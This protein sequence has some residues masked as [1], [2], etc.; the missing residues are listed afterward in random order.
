MPYPRSDPRFWI[1]MECIIEYLLRSDY[2]D[3]FRLELERGRIHPDAHMR[4]A[5][6]LLEACIQRGSIK[7]MSVLLEYG[8]N[9]NPTTSNNPVLCLLE[10]MARPYFSVPLD[11]H[12]RMAQL[13]KAAGSRLPEGARFLCN[14]RK[15][16]TKASQGKVALLFVTNPLS[17]R[18]LAVHKIR[19]QLRQVGE[20][21]SRFAQA[22]REFFKSPALR[23]SLPV[24]VITD[25]IETNMLMCDLKV[26]GQ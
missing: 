5:T 7:C 4:S 23:E 25:M 18:T 6:S 24:S 14:D 1:M 20:C 21:R 16:K 11:T 3:G 17:L 15:P 19:D 26:V 8:A 13:L 22:R 10:L 2:E 9:T 12:L